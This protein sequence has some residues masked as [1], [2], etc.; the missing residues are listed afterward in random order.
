MKLSISWILDHIA[1]TKNDIALPDLVKQFNAKTAE[2]DAAEHI[3]TELAY[4]YAVNI[5]EILDQAVVVSCKEL[6]TSFNLPQRKDPSREQG[7]WYL[8]K[9]DGSEVRWATLSDVGS[10]KD[11]LMGSLYMSDREAQGSW[12]DTVEQ[13]DTIITID[14]KAITNRPDLWGHRGCARE[15][16]ALAG[17]MLIQEEHLLADTMIKHYDRKAPA[18]AGQSFA[19]SLDDE[20]CGSTCRRFS[21]LAVPVVTYRASLPWMA[22]RLARI[23]M[24]PIDALV[25]MTN[26]VM[27]DI[28]QPMHAFDAERLPSKHI[29][30]RCARTGE[31]LRLL[32]GDEVTLEPSDRVISAGDSAVSVAGVMGGFA[33]SVT[34]TTKSLFLES[35]NFEPIPIRLTATRLKKRTESSTR[36]EKN[37]DPNQNTQG[38]LRYLKLL[39]EAQIPYEAEE[40]ITSLGPLWHEKVIEVSYELILSKIGMEVSIEK[41]ISILKNLDFGVVYEHDRFIVTVP[42][43]RAIKDVTIPEDIVE[44]VARFVGYSKIAPVLPERK[45][46]AF[47]T[48]RIERKKRLK[49]ILA[50]GLSMHEVQTYAFYDEALLKKLSYDPLDAPRIANPLSEHWQRLVTS[51]VPN[52]IGCVITNQAVQDSL[53][54][55]EINRVWH[56]AKGPIEVQECEGIYHTESQECGGIWY[57]KKA[58]IDFYEGKA[59]VEQM[60]FALGLTVHWLKPAK[61]LAPWYDIYQSAELWC[62]KRVIGRAGKCSSSFLG[63]VLEGDAFIFELD[64]IFLLNARNEQAQYVPLAKY[65]VTEQDI[66]ILV[67]RSVTVAGLENAIGRADIRIM[68]VQLVDSFEKPDWPDKKSLTFRY[69]AADK[70]GT[71][72][73][74]AIETIAQ[75]VQRAVQDL[76]GEVR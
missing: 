30:V 55:F 56:V 39:Q 12:R 42:T 45:V 4:L 3:V 33:T 24:R 47:N 8:V 18:Q 60:M 27:C 32:D 67:S 61:A 13:E 49:H 2:I 51:L 38:I 29:Q 37:I 19:L 21:G 53:R 36:Y 41:I 10:A 26:Y 28:G 68:K 57:E 5:T 44:E 11:G 46:M 17:K 48:R 25:D 6:G 23:D 50:Y 43:F 52:L 72:T 34:K 9:K 35:A 54:F 64:A 73:K 15:M 69:T 59:L 76:G 31:K 63:Q 65:P 7:F 58:P 62:G 14:N 40:A 22:F 75:H 20:A 74:E 16:A 70:E 1:T 71:L 66:S